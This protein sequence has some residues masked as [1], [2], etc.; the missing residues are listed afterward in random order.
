MHERLSEMGRS[1]PPV[2]SQSPKPRDTYTKE[3][4]VEGRE[5]YAKGA[6][7]E[8]LSTAQSRDGGLDEGLGGR[9]TPDATT[10]GTCVVT[11]FTCMSVVG[12]DSVRDT[13]M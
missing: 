1:L 5:T 12:L 2:Q 4:A 3:T 8:D 11:T 9:D 13:C 10:Q 7:S 6:A